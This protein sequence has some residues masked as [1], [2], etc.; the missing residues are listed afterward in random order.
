MSTIL[1]YLRSS[2]A[3]GADPVQLPRTLLILLQLIKELST[4]RILSTRKHLQSVSPE[5]FHVLGTI[6][7][8]KVN[9]W[10]AILEHGGAAEGLLMETIEQSLVSLKVLRRL[11]ISGFEHPGRDQEVQ[12]F[13]ALTCEHFLRFLSFSNHSS[14]LPEQVSHVIQK[15]AIQLSKLHVDMAKTHPASFALFPQSI[16]LVNSY[17][18][19]LSDLSKD[20]VNLGADD[21]P[22]G[23]S[24]SQRIG[25]RALILIRACA[26]MVFNPALTFKY[27]TAN[28]KEERNRAVERV[29]SELF[30]DGFVVN[31]M[32][33]IV[34][35]FFCLRNA[36]FQE[37]TEEP[38]SW[39]KREE[40][41]TDGWEFSIRS[42]SEKLFLDLV[43][44]F[45]N[46]L[47]AP[48]LDAFY[49]IAREYQLYIPD[50]DQC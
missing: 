17:W 3:P 30:T 29:K 36:E 28:D 7:V 39:E 22:E 21:E 13:W 33:L 6:Y 11:I 16:D 35:N 45:K 31:T 49:S 8:E 26:K 48:L 12:S 34:R 32:V 40:V 43:I 42:C 2:T 46:L 9:Q 27:Q 5:V 37:W 24:I 10:V 1:A 18:A 23:Q 20:Y 14:A 19:A 4:A 15:H 41:S 44:N 25:L 47:I 50:G 38:E